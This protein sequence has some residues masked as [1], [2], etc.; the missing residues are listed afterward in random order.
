LLS[1][2]ETAE[3]PS[4]SKPGKFRL[5]WPKSRASFVLIMMSLLAAGVATTLWLSTQAIADSYQLERVKQ[6]NATLAERAEQLQRN[7]AQQESIASL[8]QKAKE[9]GMVPGG[10]PARILSNSDGSTTLFGEPKAAVAPPPPPPPPVQTPPATPTM[11]IEGD[12]AANPDQ[13]DAQAPAGQQLPPEQNP[14]P[15]TTDA[16]QVPAGSASPAVSAPAGASS[17][18]QA[19][20]QQ[21]Q[22]SQPQPQQAAQQGPILGGN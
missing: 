15:P 14:V 1:R 11:P 19:P 7:V 13:P 5:S 20:P 3:K 22:P 4:V 21:P 9:L 18:E 6:D 16:A 2:P 12:V 8:A 17:V 10:D